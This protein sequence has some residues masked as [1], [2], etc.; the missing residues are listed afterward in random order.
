MM[1]LSEMDHT[2]TDAK[3]MAAQKRAIKLRLR[4]LILECKVSS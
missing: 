4:E 2:I 3:A 1:Q